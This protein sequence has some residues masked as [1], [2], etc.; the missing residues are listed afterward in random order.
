[1]AK[2]ILIV[3]D[4]GYIRNSL[5]A[6]LTAAGFFVVGEAKD[7]LE[8]ISKFKKLS[9]DIV[10]MDLVMPNMDGQQALRLIKSIDPSVIVVMVTS[11]NGIDKIVECRAAGASQY[12]VKPFEAEKV[13]NVF[14]KL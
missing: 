10:A 14:S 11:M 12:I 1:M 8:A 13:I 5:K 3:D 4:S 2:R 6:I 7:G 9:P